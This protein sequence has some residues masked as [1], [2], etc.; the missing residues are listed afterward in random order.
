MLKS[1]ENTKKWSLIRKSF[2]GRQQYHIKD[3]LICFITEELCYKR[4]KIRYLFKKNFL[5]AYL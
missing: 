4:E 5:K 3:Q 2:K 1:L